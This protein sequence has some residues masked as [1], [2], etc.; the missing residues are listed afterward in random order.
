MDKVY[1]I[2]TEEVLQRNTYVVADSEQEA[3]EKVKQLYKDKKLQFSRKFD[4]QKVNF[5]SV[6]KG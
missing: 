6:K 3:I 5:Y 2:M 4:L 1:E